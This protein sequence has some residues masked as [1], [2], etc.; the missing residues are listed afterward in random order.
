MKEGDEQGDSGSDAPA[1][2]VGTYGK[3]ADGSL[4]GQWV[5]LTDFND[6]GEFM[7]YI[8]E[9]HK[10]EKDPEFM[11]QDYENF[12]E[13]WYSESGMSEETFNKILEWYDMDDGKKDA[14]EAYLDAGLGDSIE[15]FEDAYQGKY[16]SE[17]D[18]AEQLIADVGMPSEN[19]DY[20]F[21]YDSFG[22]DLMYDYHTG[23]E[24]EEDAE[25]NPQDPD[26]YYDQDNY[27]MGEYESDRQVAEDFVDNMGGVDQLGQE[28][29]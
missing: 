28:T 18:F 10:D 8:R 16:N 26:H 22:R 17:L 25:G 19:M 2:Y 15:D 29:I 24:G 3:Y 12:P 20:Y 14:Y 6:Y 9:L 5:K 4:K 1:V 23:D 27:D 13:C 21:D 7:D 11:F